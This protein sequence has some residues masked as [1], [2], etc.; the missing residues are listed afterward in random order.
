MV[1]T[2]R[3]KPKILVMDE[4]WKFIRQKKI[5][6]FIMEAWKTFRKENTTTIGISQ[7][8]IG[9]IASNPTLA[10]AILQSTETWFLLEQGGDE[11][12]RDV[13]ALLNLT[14]GQIDLLS[15]LREA[16]SVAEDGTI[17]LYREALMLRAK[18][19]KDANSG[20]IRI[21]AM[22]SEYWIFTTKPN[23]AAL[24]EDV[25][26]RFGGDVYQAARFL[27]AKYPGGLDLFDKFNIITGKASIEGVD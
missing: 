18:S 5:V 11:F 7:N 1:M 15:N 27:G 10:G 16:K 8:I 6:E 25:T 17:S 4:M 22:P 24:M 20:I 13:G 26:L 3:R 12:V 2:N 9:D 21:K 19:S 14:D 23:E